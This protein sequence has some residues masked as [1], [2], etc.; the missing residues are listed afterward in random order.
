M[1]IALKLFF[2]PFWSFKFLP[3]FK[4]FTTLQG[5]A[6]DICKKHVDAAIARVQDTDDSVIAKL[7]RA[8]GRE[9]PIP[10]IMGA[11]ALQVIIDHQLSALVKS[12]T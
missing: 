11:D 6:F 2:L 3:M 10:M 7:V 12:L 4:K 1:S 9:S 5:E 8:C